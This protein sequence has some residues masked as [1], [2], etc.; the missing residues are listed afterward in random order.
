ML[1]KSCGAF[2]TAVG[3]ALGVMGV[4]GGCATTPPADSNTSKADPDSSYRGS[5]QHQPRLTVNGG[6]HETLGQLVRAL[7][8]SE[9][10]GGIV[11]VSG[12]EERPTPA[13][14][15]TRSA[16]DTGLQ[17]LVA[18]LNLQ[19]L[20]KG[21]YQFILP[22]GYESLA[23]LSVEDE[24][25]P[26]IAK[27]RASLAL[28]AGTDLFN[29]LAVISTVLDVTVLADNALA[30]VWCGELFLQDVPAAHLLNGVLQSA[31]VVP[32]AV[33][34]ESTSD[35][36]FIRSVANGV[37]LDRCLNR[38]AVT[39]GA[40][41]L[42]SRRVSVRVPAGLGDDEFQY[43]V[44]PLAS[45]L[46]TLSDAFG[47]SVEADASLHAFPVNRAHFRNMSIEDVLTLIVRQWPVPDFGFHVEEE[48]IVFAR[49]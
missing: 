44:A 23:A 34:V 14:S 21:T 2:G 33:V 16:Y 13:I 25:H 35:Y 37:D 48:R 1:F 20:D 31:R 42:L 24:L 8:E 26:D 43:E 49:K 29:A 38:G 4:L 9:S 6:E 36:V 19:V 17:R 5:V 47:V 41:A 28:G 46:G 3:I 30:D 22:S 45:V 10:G 18:P 12:L 7:G 32:A 40:S 15:L 39:S 11:L 27:R